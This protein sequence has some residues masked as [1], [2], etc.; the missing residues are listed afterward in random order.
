MDLSKLKFAA[1]PPQLLTGVDSI[2]RQHV[3]I[4]TIINHLSICSQEGQGKEQLKQMMKFLEG[5]VTTHFDDEEKYMKKYNYPHLN[6]HRAKHEIFKKFVHDLKIKIQTEKSSS[7]LHIK[8]IKTL[9]EWI[10]NHV[11]KVDIIMAAHINNALKQ[12]SK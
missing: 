9:K 7:I 1:L 4:I 10:I 11:T 3:A 8:A 6:D 12:N 5:Y 2:D